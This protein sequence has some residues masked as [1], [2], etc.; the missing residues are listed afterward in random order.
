MMDDRA[1]ALKKIP[2]LPGTSAQNQ[3]AMRIFLGQTRIFQPHVPDYALITKHL[4]E[5]TTKT[6]SWDKST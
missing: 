1:A 3:T 2:F 5:M 6:I 4:D